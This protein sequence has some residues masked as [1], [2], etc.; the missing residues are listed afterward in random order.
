[1]ESTSRHFWGRHPVSGRHRRIIGGW[2]KIFHKEKVSRGQALLTAFDILAILAAFIIMGAGL[3]RRRAL[4]KGGRD[5]PMKG[6]LG[7]LVRYLLGHQK[8]LKNRARGISHLVLFWGVMIPLVIIVLSQFAFTMPRFAAHALSL[9]TDIL[10]IAMLAAILFFLIRRIGT[11]QQ[12]QG[13]G[14]P[15]WPLAVFLFILL[16]GFLAEGTR[17]SMVHPA[18]SGISPVGSLFSL[19]LPDSP[20]LMQVMIRCHFFGVL[21]FIAM[22]PFTFMRHLTAAAL[23]VYFKKQG[24]RGELSPVSWDGG[25]IGA[26]RISDFSRKQ[27]LDGEACVSCGR[28]E[29]NCPAALSGKPLSPKKIMRHIFEQMESWR[30]HSAPVSHLEEDITA[31][32][33]WSCTT[34]MACVEH[35][36]VF[37]DPL[38]KII[39]MRRH[40][41]MGAGKLPREARPMIRNLEVFGDVQGKGIAYREDWAFNRDVPV[42]TEGVSGGNESV[43]LWVGCSGAFHPRYQDVARAMVK[44]LKTGGVAFG[45]LGKGEL[46]CGD[47]ARRLGEE[48]LFL[49]LARRNI[50]RFRQ[51]NI[52]TI[53]ALCPHCLNTLKNEYPRLDAEEGSRDLHVVSAVEFVWELIRENRITLKYPI[54]KQIAVHDPC[55]LGRVNQIYEPL[56]EVIRAVPGT[57][58]REL[59]R[60]RES[61]FCCGGGGGRMW[62]RESLGENINTLRSRE[63]QAAGVDTVGTAC[64]YCLTMLDDG[65]KSLEVEDPP[66]VLDIIEIVASSLG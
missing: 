54:R 13:R 57:E 37:I 6:D 17:L 20:R 41:V 26:A 33:I 15:V 58:V 34:C 48:T 35:C 53:V 10:G 11:G 44:I 39:D 56:R 55:Y 30:P 4:W 5:E 60:N 62:L 40:I 45:I 49:D 24:P 7:G 32:E 46:C 64:P 50:G 66:E 36:P 19:F 61:G 21:L 43:L 29:E 14:N 47:P 65:I 52:G 2:F 18:F 59:E 3:A 16:T 9:L 1:L 22:I 63:V 12:E 8:I 28:C 23:N 27:L 38:D 42:L 25:P 51:V 31:D